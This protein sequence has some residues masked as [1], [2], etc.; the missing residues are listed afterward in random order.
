M[1]VD[2][3]YADGVDE[4]E[5]VMG[6]L[7]RNWKKLPYPKFLENVFASFWSNKPC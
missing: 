1:G 4:E 6:V 7:D 2:D 5:F 3:A